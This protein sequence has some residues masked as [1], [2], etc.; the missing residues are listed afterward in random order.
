MLNRFILL[1]IIACAVIPFCQASETEDIPLSLQE[2]WKYAECNTIATNLNIYADL[3]DQ[4]LTANAINKTLE[5]LLNQIPFIN[6]TAV[7]WLELDGYLE[8]CIKIT[9]SDNAQMDLSLQTFF[10]ENEAQSNVMLNIEGGNDIEQLISY[11][12]I[13]D[14]CLSLLVAEGQINCSILGSVEKE[15]AEQEVIKIIA[16]LVDYLHCDITDF[17]VDKQVLSVCA[18][19]PMLPE[20]TYGWSFNVQVS[21]RKNDDGSYNFYLGYPAISASY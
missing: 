3:T 17:Y 16:R 20:M 8:G 18:S 9:L 6:T 2:A 5:E 21:A 11:K 15:F 1:F 12:K 13:I 10:N 14:D 7:E 19:S 4:L